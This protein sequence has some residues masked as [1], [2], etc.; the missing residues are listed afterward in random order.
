MRKKLMSDEK[1]ISEESLMSEESLDSNRIQAQEPNYDRQEREYI[2]DLLGKFHNPAITVAATYGDNKKSIFEERYAKAVADFK[3]LSAKDVLK[4]VFNAG[5][6]FDPLFDNPKFDFENSRILSDVDAE[7]FF[8]DTLN[9]KQA[10]NKS[11]F[12]ILSTRGFVEK[13]RS[14]TIR[15]VMKQLIEDKNSVF[16]K[17]LLS[18]ENILAKIDNTFMQK[19]ISEARTQDPVIIREVFALDGFYEKFTSFLQD[20]K[21][22]EIYKLFKEASN[23]LIDSITKFLQENESFRNRVTETFVAKLPK[24]TINAELTTQNNAY[25]KL[26]YQLPEALKV[27]TQNVVDLKN[28]LAAA[29]HVN[30]H[31]FLKSLNGEAVKLVFPESPNEIDNKILQN[32]LMACQDS[33]VDQHTWF[34]TA[35]NQVI[36][37]LMKNTEIQSKLDGFLQTLQKSDVAGE[38][39]K[40]DLFARELILKGKTVLFKAMISSNSYHKSMGKPEALIIKAVESKQPDILIALADDEYFSG[41]SLKDGSPQKRAFIAKFESAVNHARI[42]KDYPLLS[43]LFKNFPESYISASL[44]E[45][46][47]DFYC[48]IAEHPSFKSH[49]KPAPQDNLGTTTQTF[50]DPCNAAPSFEDLARGFDTKK[51]DFAA[52]QSSQAEQR[53]HY[54]TLLLPLPEPKLEDGINSNTENS[55]TSKGN[56]AAISTPPQIIYVPVDK[57]V[58]VE[59]DFGTKVM[60]A[61]PYFV[62]ATLEAVGAAWIYMQ[63]KTP[64]MIATFTYK[65][66]EF[67]NVHKYCQ[68]IGCKVKNHVTDL[69][70]ETTFNQLHAAYKS[71]FD[72]AHQH[73]TMTQQNQGNYFKQGLQMVFVA[74]TF[75]V[76]ALAG[77]GIYKVIDGDPEPKVDLAVVFLAEFADLAL[78]VGIGS[79][80]TGATTLAV[81]SGLAIVSAYGISHIISTYAT[82]QQL[83]NE[84]IFQNLSSSEQATP[85][86]DATADA[87]AIPE[88]NPLHND[89]HNHNA[90]DEL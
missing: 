5:L 28:K 38:Q 11:L 41:R 48:Q 42:T 14:E 67:A 12:F 78:L 86:N 1:L 3:V 70:H 85:K 68:S 30:A 81:D 52:L 29:A 19:F 75:K 9:N 39:S 26:L 24:T 72:S 45:K 37:Y 10:D 44:Y 50:P 4:K 43:I 84:E 58:Y 22:D 51:V 57:T 66:F 64:Q 15:L 74:Q 61:A 2:A 71:N 35:S 8:K 25:F 55:E 87:T 73:F 89:Q 80:V 62:A 17:Y 65:A 36:E 18:S 27:Y 31:S 56:H 63:A 54:N 13:I 79:T 69:A 82:N 34:T 47:L 76:I 90:Q 23:G 33:K 21:D 60:E 49:A 20:R 88:N 53:E 40:V 6:V 59:K 32:F 7:S 16:L 77:D 46:F 83:T